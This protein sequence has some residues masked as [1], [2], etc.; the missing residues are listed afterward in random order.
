MKVKVEGKERGKEEKRRR[1]FSA[2]KTISSDDEEERSS[3]LNE[4]ISNLLPLP[5]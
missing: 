1:R 5:L 3:D 2:R 4:P